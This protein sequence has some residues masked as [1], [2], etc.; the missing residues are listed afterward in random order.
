MPFTHNQFTTSRMLRLALFIILCL[1][2]SHVNATEIDHADIAPLAKKSLLLDIEKYGSL[3]IAVGERGHILISH[4]NKNWTQANVETR[5]ML[6]SVVIIN[7]DKALAVGHNSIIVMTGDGGSNWKRVFI[8][9]TDE[10]PLLDIVFLDQ[11]KGIA[12]GAYGFMYVT[13]DGGLSWKKKAIV[14]NNKEFADEYLA[15]N[16][17]LHLNAITFFDK[18]QIYIATEAGYL[19][20]SVDSGKTWKLIETPYG[21]SFFGTVV[22]SK[23]EL[24]MYGL[25]GNVYRTN[26]SGISWDKIET[27]TTEMLTSHTVL[28]NGDI[29][30]S[31][32]GGTVLISDDNGMSFS[33]I[34]LNIHK[35]F[36]ALVNTHDDT[37]VFT[38]EAG[39][40]TY[41]I[42]SLRSEK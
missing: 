7:E 14:I 17:D 23:N 15:K 1:L 27:N 35:G 9:T 13:D 21:G 38:G 37:F 36:S 19:L 22:L 11:L 2:Y 32:M 24:L 34:K 25:K 8:S 20:H 6:T 26:D 40:K 41:T 42:N 33:K 29:I 3:L 31:G 4:D 28:A 5:N 18:K 10:A 16:F 30:L 12:V 39:I